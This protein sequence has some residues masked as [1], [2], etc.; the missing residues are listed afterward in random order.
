MA[1]MR[2]SCGL[3]LIIVLQ[4][5]LGAGSVQLAALMTSSSIPHRIAHK[6]WTQDRKILA[7]LIQNRVSEA[8]AVDIHPGAK[9]GRGVL[10]DHATGVVIGE[11]AVVG[12]NCSILHGVT[13]GGTGKQCGD[14]HPK[15]GD[16]VLIGAGT[17]VLGNITIGEGAKV[18]S[19]SVVLKDVPP[20]TTAVGNPA[21][22]IGGKEN[23]K[24]LDKIPGL[25]MD[26]TSYLTEWSD[27]VI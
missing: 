11:T 20:H 4:N 1:F 18:G 12:E 13:L 19:G 8:F 26:Q 10:L 25:S 16:G 14:R 6:L 3:V 17:C 24:M 2:D 22:L 9:I 7:L 23:P 5:Q 15:I 27:Y 21:R